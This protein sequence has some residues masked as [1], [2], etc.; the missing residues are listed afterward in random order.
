MTWMAEVIVEMNEMID[1]VKPPTLRRWKKQWLT[2]RRV[3]T[4]ELNRKRKSINAQT[5]TWFRKE[6]LEKRDRTLKRREWEVEMEAR[7]NRQYP[8]AEWDAFYKRE[9]AEE[10]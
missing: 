7:T 8:R 10:K 9:V 3:R 6:W 5:S 4:I 2:T 1:K